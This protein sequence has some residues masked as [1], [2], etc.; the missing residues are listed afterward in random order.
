MVANT[1][2]TLLL[3]LLAARRAATSDA[4]R[5]AA[6]APRVIA[7]LAAAAGAATQLGRPG[8]SGALLDLGLGF[9]ASAPWRS[10]SSSCSETRRCATPM[11]R[12]VRRFVPKREGGPAGPAA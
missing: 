2:G 8:L 3:A 7:A 6:P 4:S 11:R 10:R 12:Q 1:L 9:T 5:R